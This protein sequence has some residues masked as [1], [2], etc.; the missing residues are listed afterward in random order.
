MSVQSHIFSFLSPFNKA[1]YAKSAGIGAYHGG[2][3]NATQN[4]EEEKTLCFKEVTCRNRSPWAGLT[5]YCQN[6]I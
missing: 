5:S 2:R 6:I 4:V 3:R 1:S